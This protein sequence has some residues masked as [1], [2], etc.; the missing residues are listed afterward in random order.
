M[1]LDS[2]R[3]DA[4]RGDPDQH[5][6][7]LAGDRELP[8]AAGIDEDLGPAIELLLGLLVGDEREQ[9]PCVALVAEVGEGE[10]HR[11]RRSLH[12]VGAAAVEAIAVEQRVELPGTPGDDVDVA[13]EDDR[14]QLR[15][16][17]LGDHDRQVA[18]GE[19]PGR[20]VTGL[21]PALDEAGAQPDPLRG[22]GVVADQLFGQ[23]PLLHRERVERGRSWRGRGRGGTAAASGRNR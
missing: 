19:L 18:D 3:Q 6:G 4:L 14:G 1:D 12:V 11:R 13:V 22:R 23:Q 8:G 10:H 5:V 7:R 9:D 2:Q 21:E 16:P 15:R 20:D 17:D